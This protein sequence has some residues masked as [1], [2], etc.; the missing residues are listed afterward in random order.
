MKQANDDPEVK[1]LVVDIA[2]NSGGSLDVV[3]AMTALM[4]GQSHFYSENVLTGQKQKI[5]YDVDC[6]FDGVFDDKDKEVWKGYQLKY[7]VMTTDNSFSCGNLVPAA[8]KGLYGI[9]LIGGQPFASNLNAIAIK[10]Y[11]IICFIESVAK[12]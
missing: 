1:N 8:L 3:M 4:G 11:C 10:D 2:L 7:A 12:L 9:T 6:N 5:Y